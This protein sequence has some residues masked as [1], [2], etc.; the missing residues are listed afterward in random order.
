MLTLKFD[1]RSARLISSDASGYHLTN[2]LVKRRDAVAVSV[3]VYLDGVAEPFPGGTMTLGLKQQ[4]KHSGAIVAT[5]TLTVSASS[6]VGTLSLNT[7]EVSTLFAGVGLPPTEPAYVMLVA[8]LTHSTGWTAE[9][10][11]VRCENDYIA[12]DEPAP[13]ESTSALTDEIAR[14]QA[15]EALLIPLAQKGVP[16]GV[17]TLDAN[18]DLVG[19]IIGRMILFSDTTTVPSLGEQFTAVDSL[20]APTQ[21]QFR[22][23]DGVTAGGLI[24][25][26]S[27]I[28]LTAT[29]TVTAVNKGR[30]IVLGNGITVTFNDV[31]APVSFVSRYTVVLVHGSAIIGN[32]TYRQALSN[33]GG[34]NEEIR[35]AYGTSAWL[36]RIVP[37]AFVT[38]RTDG[39]NLGGSGAV[40]TGLQ[41]PF[42]APLVSINGGAGGANAS[43]GTGI[44]GNG[45]PQASPVLLVVNAGVGGAAS[46]N[47]NGGNA[48]TVLP[49][50]SVPF[51]VCQ[52]SLGSGGAAG[53]GGNG[54]NAATNPMSN[55]IALRLGSGSGGMGGTSGGVGGTGGRFLGSSC[56]AILFQAGSGGVGGTSGSGGAG[57]NLT[58]S[59]GT[60]I[61]W[62][63]GGNGGG[64]SGT[65]TGGAGGAIA[66]GSA[67]FGLI[68]LVS[69]A[70]G[71]AVD[72]NGGAGGKSGAISLNGGNG[73]A[74]VTTTAGAAGGNAGG[75]LLNGAAASGT[76]A[77]GN[78]GTINL[79][80]QVGL[81]APTITGGLGTP[82]GVVTA[83]VASLFLRMDGG[84]GTCMYVKESGTG[85]TGWVAK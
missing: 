12:G 71:F 26:D 42:A 6:Y 51:R 74:A 75:I 33:Y 25:S 80:G 63:Q 81:D 79:S 68:E 31:T 52:I 18:G 72:A 19:P 53:T 39:T 1:K 83:P 44:G 27:D 70:G 77:G 73:S 64:S 10:V 56:H 15:A 38:P 50:A 41:T 32:Q 14:A 85:N 7:N 76:T 34:G 4:G 28:I 35:R 11:P 13:G 2:A 78:G 69:G 17:A 16:L 43:S 55:S 8:E 49:D 30:Y 23:G 65:G 57:G 37:S 29:Q 20:T 36:T 60:G 22:L 67:N 61:L 66:Y 59:P 62:V 82:E 24:S 58:T 45:T 3:T 9:T 5:A 21:A 48:A 84:A 47:F 40:G 46:G 54:G